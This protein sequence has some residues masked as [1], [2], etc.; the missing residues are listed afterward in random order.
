MASREE[1]TLPNQE[2]YLAILKTSLRDVSKR[3][4]SLVRQA[5]SSQDGKL[6]ILV[7]GK[8]GQGKSTLINGIL[9]REVAPEGAGSESCTKTVAKYSFTV[10]D[11]CVNAFDSACR[12]SRLQ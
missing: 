9:G 3:I 12:S 4:N 6:N 7:A 1:S 11:V 10:D 8:T 5:L 2:Q